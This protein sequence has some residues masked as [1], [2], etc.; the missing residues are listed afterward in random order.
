MYTTCTF[1]EAKQKVAALL[2]EQ[3]GLTVTDLAEKADLTEAEACL[4]L[5]E[6]LVHVTDGKHAE[7][8]CTQLTTWGPVTTI[9]NSFGSIFEVKAPFPKGKTNHGYYNLLSREGLNGHLRLDLITH[10]GFVSK[11]FHGMETHHIAF[12]NGEG[13]CV[14]RVYL[15]RDKA[16]N[17]LPEQVELYQAMK[18][19]FV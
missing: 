13:N 6:E 8:I 14:F 19:E 10:I 9:V 4:A 3:P 7:A 16:R 17:L 11:M 2:A 12:F 1:D 5:P 18:K 15:G